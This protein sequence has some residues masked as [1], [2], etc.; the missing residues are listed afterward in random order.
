MV[1]EDPADGCYRSY[2]RYY[3]VECLRLLRNRVQCSVKACLQH[4]CGKPSKSIPY[5]RHVLTFCTGG[6][7]FH[8]ACRTAPLDG[9]KTGFKS[10]PMGYLG[11]ART[12]YI[13]TPVSIPTTANLWDRCLYV[14]DLDCCCWSFHISLRRPMLGGMD[15]PLPPVKETLTREFASVQDTT[16]SGRVALIAFVTA[17]MSTTSVI[18]R[19]LPRASR[20]P[21]K[22]EHTTALIAE[23]AG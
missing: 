13:Y 7:V 1:R 8:R 15:N 9:T 2:P 4:C 6:L 3:R 18:S 14:R 16:K 23:E 17:T 5:Y 21:F 20:D 22:K 10:H 19:P 12:R 11:A